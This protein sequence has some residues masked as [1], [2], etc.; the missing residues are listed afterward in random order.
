[1]LHRSARVNSLAATTRHWQIACYHTFMRVLVLILVVANSGAAQWRGDIA[2]ALIWDKLKGNCPANLNQPDL[3][4]KVVVLSLG[5]DFPIPQSVADW[6]N[7]P[8]RFPD[9]PVVVLQVVTGP[10]FLIDQA[11]KDATYQ[12]CILIDGAG[13]NRENFKLSSSTE[14][15]VID[16][17]GLIAG[18]SRYADGDPIERAIRAVLDNRLETGLSE[19]PPEGQAWHARPAENVSWNVLIEPAKPDVPHAFEDGPDRYLARNQ[20]L[21]FIVS[22]LWNTPPALILLPDKAKSQRY[23][24]SAHI[25]VSG[26]DLL[27]KL[28]REAVEKHFELLIDRELRVTRAYVMSA[29]TRPSTHLQ[30]AREDEQEMTGGGEGSIIGTHQTTRNIAATLQDLLGIPVVDEADMNGNYDYSATS[31]LAGSEAAL[32]LARQLGFDLKPADRPVEILVARPA[33]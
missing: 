21:D 2:P 7:L 4:G 23:T 15:V 17:G 28:C 5:D 20:S 1:M 9:E 16:R 14:T 8:K 32:D 12:G 22:T 11:L 6:N 29:S 30:A 3:K 10:E 27:L 25:P 26:Y 31:S 18:Y 24:V 13:A 33:Y 19:S